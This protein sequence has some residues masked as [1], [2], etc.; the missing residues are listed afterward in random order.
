MRLCFSRDIAAVLRMLTQ[1]ALAEAQLRERI[2]NWT[3]TKAHRIPL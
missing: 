3:L 2:P 1:D